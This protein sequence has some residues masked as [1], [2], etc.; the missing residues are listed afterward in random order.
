MSKVELPEDRWRCEA[1]FSVMKFFH[2]QREVFAEMCTLA[3][4]HLLVIVLAPGVS[5]W[6]RRRTSSG[7]PIVTWW[8]LFVTRQAERDMMWMKAPG[9]LC[10]E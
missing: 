3:E 7:T 6:G 4:L 5:F 10:R 8:A 2:M 9:H 1:P